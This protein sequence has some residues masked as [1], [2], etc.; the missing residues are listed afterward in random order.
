MK[1]VQLIEVRDGATMPSEITGERL[2]SLFHPR[3]VAL[4]GASDKSAFSML[5][6]RNLWNSASVRVRT[7]ST[8]AACRR[9]GSR[10]SAHVR[11]SGN[12]SMSPT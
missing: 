8:G 6:Y 5:A 2:T 3:S 4:V 1:F 12:R 9:T 7:W 11:R 10:R